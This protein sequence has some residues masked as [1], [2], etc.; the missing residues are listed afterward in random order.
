MCSVCEDDPVVPVIDEEMI[1]AFVHIVGG[2][3]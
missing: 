3:T 1:N 2:H